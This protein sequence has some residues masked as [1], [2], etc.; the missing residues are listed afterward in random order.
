MRCLIPFLAGLV[1]VNTWAEVRPWATSEETQALRRDMVAFFQGAEVHHPGA[2]GNLALEAK[3]AARFDESGLE[4]G[5]I[6]FTAPS[7][8]PGRTTVTAPGKEPVQLFPLHPTLFRPGNFTNKEFAARLVY[9]GH[10]TV[11][12]LIAVDGVDLDGALA[13]MEFD[14]GTAWMR[15]LR[16]GV[17]GFIFIG[18]PSDSHYDAVGK[19]VISEISLPRFYIEPKDGEILK[20]CAKD[21]TTVQVHAEPSRWENR[22]LRDLWVLVPGADNDL[23]REVCVILAPMDSA[24]I[25]PDKAT[26][27]QTAANLYFLLQL[28]DQFKKNPPG[29][30]VL[31]AAVNAHTQNFLGER[32]LAWYLLSDG[33]EKI[34]D[35]LNRDIEGQRM[36]EAWYGR[37]KL[38]GF[39]QEDEN[40][41]I[42][43]RS[44]T[45]DSSGLN[46]TVK[47]PL[48]ALARR[49]VN[50]VKTKQLILTVTPN[51]SKKEF[52]ARRRQL[53]TE[54][55]KFTNV[56][57]LFNKVGI[58]TKLSELSPEE[59]RILKGYVDEI[60]RQNRHCA[61][62]NERQL[63]T[64]DNNGR[65][66][67]VLQ[68]KNVPM[69]LSLELDWQSEQVGFNSF[70]PLEGINQLGVRWGNHLN[71]I[72]ED[73][74]PVMQDAKP[75]LLVDTMT[76]VGGASES[77]YFPGYRNRSC[78]TVFH[79]AHQTP[80]LAL[81]NVFTCYGRAFLPDDAFDRLPYE[82]IA[83]EMAYSSAMLRA[84]LSDAAI[85]ASSDMDPKVLL[86]TYARST[87]WAMQ[88]KTYRF[89][90]LSAAVLPEIPVPGSV[91][92][93]YAEN[94]PPVS[95]G[96]VLNACLALTDDRASSLEYGLNASFLF[97]PLTWIESY[98]ISAFHYD[99]DFVRVD[100]AI[101]A[102]DIHK[103]MSSNID[104][105]QNKMLDVKMLALFECQEYP[106][107]VKDDPSL[108]SAGVIG[109]SSLIPLLAVGNSV[110]RKYGLS[111]VASMLSSKE[112]C[113]SPLA[114]M[115]FSRED[116]I[117]LLTPEKRAALNTTPEEPEGKGFASAVELG[118][119][120]FWHVA[121]DLSVLNRFRLAKLKTVADELTKDFCARGDRALQAMR[122]ARQRKDHTEYLHAFYEALGAHVKCY[123]Q[124]KQTS[125]DMLKAVVVYMALLLPFCFFFQKLVFKFVKIEA[126]MGAFAVLFVVTF[127][128]FRTIHPAFRVAQ[129]A[130]AIFIAFVMGALG[131]FVISIL[132]SRFQG[133]M[134]LLFQNYLEADA[135]V[136]YSTVGQK[137]MLVG[138]NNMKRRRIRTTL[139][140][141]TI[142]LIA[143]TM[144]SFTSISKRMNPTIIAKSKDV[145]YTGIMYH[146]PG[147]YLMDEASLAVFSDLFEKKGQMIVRRW[148]VPRAEA[149][150]YV[151]TPAGGSGSFDGL[152]GL[153]A[154]ENGFLAPLPLISGRFFSSDN[155]AEMV[156][157]SS[158]AEVLDID[159]KALGETTVTLMDRKLK[160]VG[161]LDDSRFRTL[162]DI[163]DAP[164]MPIKRV[165]K[166]QGAQEI[167]TETLLAR[168][169]GEKEGTEEQTFFYMDTSSL[170]IV[171]VDL[172]RQIRA[173]PYSVSVKFKREEPIWPSIDLIL[174]T[175]RAKFFVASM[176]PFTIGSGREAS[177][178]APGIYYVGSNYKTAIGGLAK[179]LI[180]LLIA[181]SIIINTM[182]GSVY[183]RK[184][185]IAVYNA[186]GLNPHHIGMF[187]L[188]ES[189]VY[190]V[191]GAVGGY[192]IGQLLSMLLN[193][194][195]WVKEINLN[196][197]SLSVAY[198]ILFTIAIVLL[199]T[200]Y[201]AIVATKAAVPSGKRK[202]SLPPHDGHT[203]N[204]VFPFIYDPTI[205]Q[206]IIAYLDAYFARFTEA[207][208]GNLIAERTR[209]EKGQD[210]RE[211]ATFT[212]EY[213]LALAPY[214]L[215]VT[216]RVRF[217]LAYD[218]RIETYRLTMTITRISGQDTNWVTTNR[219]FLELLR[220]Y[221]M[222]WRNL[223]ASE[224]I[225]YGERARELFQQAQRSGL[226][227]L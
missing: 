107:Y 189:F 32:M 78:V 197:S 86:G 166:E 109:V 200:L 85:T 16:F 139:T 95:S 135:E 53:E 202:W 192:L 48:V 5:Q 60:I 88:C 34:R 199:S 129:A 208:I 116:R 213:Q 10:G 206:G 44:L 74:A 212:T 65:I 215:G 174:A 108:V 41:L 179:L 37:L 162:K 111:G 185:E 181:A 180:P 156:L 134:Q 159:P 114:A 137:A 124:I 42:E 18:G 154:A 224:H 130:E 43:F 140:T 92:I 15:F 39:N 17:K 87:I 9:L 12:D 104:R 145:P 220:K 38:N 165:V 8:I 176:V 83:T 173:R 122:D 221:L 149:P 96:D 210:A 100:Y 207:T 69:V 188:A 226:H 4:H 136:G 143:F 99:P 45:D 175:T 27:A 58:K 66:R 103:K 64:D 123:E 63:Q 144:L 30:S 72:L 31:L 84:V 28:L 35:T 98:R 54:R 169:I 106:L 147:M 117:K 138:V 196:Y 50:K 113:R 191:I 118:P 61:D 93:L 119:D 227:A 11:D 22:E 177:S 186:I 80:A 198:V 161:I 97:S 91:V 223:D 76:G 214:D 81:R 20:S 56:L 155:A 70:K 148:L 142:V 133:E 2:P 153:P 13:I 46:V 193:W 75:N 146:W 1:A 101:N 90:E 168:G 151:R 195:G 204:V 157:C 170:L 225:V 23:A 126:E 36:F 3:V 205:A 150:L 49:D 152:I 183:E 26:G 77:F 222:H 6:L 94:L 121:K 25:V 112:V 55:I 184:K 178:I 68:G 115:Y 203:M 158:A 164:L 29:R 57:T 171:P 127:I 201:P 59:V 131:L 216:Q 67:E 141:A 125:D 7:F 163:N 51:L 211:Q 52:N 71:R 217:H 172:A 209:Q 218:N 73:W 120:L 14:C 190:G 62:L 182:L 102:G 167:D 89:D 132:Y 33:V 110:P 21:R 219:P 128:I 160:V 47:Q 40:L 187:F 79:S 194:C 105:S 19:L 82:T 24:C